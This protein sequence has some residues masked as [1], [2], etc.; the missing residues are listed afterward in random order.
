VAGTLFALGRAAR[1]FPLLFEAASLPPILVA[2]PFPQL[3]SLRGLSSPSPASLL[4]SSSE[5]KKR[6]N[7]VLK[8]EA[9]WKEQARG[10]EEEAL[11]ERA[12]RADEAA[13]KEQAKKDEAGKGQSKQDST[14]KEAARKGSLLS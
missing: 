8:A 13:K 7:E 6:E 4:L 14:A 3:L 9:A 5:A 11:K 1:P 12:R 10:R 2:F